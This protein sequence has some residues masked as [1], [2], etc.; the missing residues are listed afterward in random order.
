MV[1]RKRNYEN[2][3]NGRKSPILKTAPSENIALAKTYVNA[4]KKVG[5]LKK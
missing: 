2:E 5:V 3:V 1:N 4:L